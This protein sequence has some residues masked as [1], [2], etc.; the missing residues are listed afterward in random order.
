MN[1]ALLQFIWQHSLYTLTGLQTTDGEP[2]TIIHSGRMNR[3][4]GPDFLEAKVKVGDTI[5]VG[6]VEIHTR[7]S[8]WLKHGHQGDPAYK[9][10]I[11][12][13]HV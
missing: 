8:N 2:L 3:D 13:A 12:R 5:L 9:N 4:A 1:E 10:Q 11:G 7:S 6:N